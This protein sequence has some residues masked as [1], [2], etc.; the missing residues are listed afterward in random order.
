MATGIASITFDR[1]SARSAGRG[2]KYVTGQVVLSTS[3][4]FY[5]S[6]IEKM[7]RRCLNIHVNTTSGVVANW[8][9]HATHQAGSL[10]TYACSGVS[11]ASAALMPFTLKGLTSGFFTAFGI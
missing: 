2:M 11:T 10:R 9:K 5:T 4:V 7:F 1:R 6:G 3:N 8:H